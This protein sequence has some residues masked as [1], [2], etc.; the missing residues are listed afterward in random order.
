[1]HR[2]QPLNKY[3]PVPNFG[4]QEQIRE[5]LSWRLVFKA[6]HFNLKFHGPVPGYL[7]F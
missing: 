7:P 2:S 5:Y 6:Q 4:I 3:W 1:M